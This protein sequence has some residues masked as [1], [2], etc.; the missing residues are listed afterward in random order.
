MGKSRRKEAELAR[1]KARE[2][3][4]AHVDDSSDI[5]IRQQEMQRYEATKK[6]EEKEKM[7]REDIQSEYREAIQNLEQQKSKEESKAIE[8]QQA[9]EKREFLEAE[10]MERE[11][12][13]SEYREAIQN[14]EQQK[15]KEESKAIE[16]QQAREKR[17]FLE[18][19]EMER[20]D[21]Q[22]EY[23][24]AIQNLEQQKSK[25]ESEAIETSKLREYHEGVISLLIE[26][27]IDDLVSNQR[28]EL[29]NSLTDTKNHQDV[30]DAFDQNA[31]EDKNVLLEQVKNDVLTDLNSDFELS[32]EFPIY[33]WVNHISEHEK[34]KSI[35]N[36]AWKI[37][38]DRLRQKGTRDK[39]TGN[40][41]GIALGNNNRGER[42]KFPNSEPDKTKHDAKKIRNDFGLFMPQTDEISGQDANDRAKR[43][44][45]IGDQFGGVAH[46]HNAVSNTFWQEEKQT[47]IEEAITEIIG[48]AT[49]QLN[50]D[51]VLLKHT[52]YA[53]PGTGDDKMQAAR[54]INYKVLVKNG[55]EYDTVINE[56]IDDRTLEGIKMTTPKETIKKR[57]EAINTYKETIKT[58]ITDYFN[59]KN[60][61]IPAKYNPKGTPQKPIITDDTTG[62][63]N[64]T[65]TRTPLRPK[66]T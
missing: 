66:A 11:D 57:R 15:S 37:G 41:S 24:E 20:E 30:L 22:S 25:E 40:S 51:D 55:N 42:E 50:R 8:N 64:P 58:K 28:I 4:Y 43:G 46:Y 2:R 7:N 53:Y 29:K 12:I 62:D 17:E 44:H 16:N 5:A 39:D 26:D 54:Y 6:H 21:I 10:E 49:N 60:K 33:T 23:R 3:K 34:I 31:H 27:K 32:E 19:E 13:Q 63:S 59:D 65:Y 48:D 61:K 9:R 36:K 38:L 35:E 52:A 14:L 56:R 1:K 45:Q 18:A 47:K